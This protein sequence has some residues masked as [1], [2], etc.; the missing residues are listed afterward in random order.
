[1]LAIRI[2]GPVEL[3]A[4]DGMIPLPRRHHRALLAILALDTRRA[5]GVNRLTSL[6]WGDHPP[7]THRANI[8]TRVSELRAILAGIG[9]DIRASGVGYLLDAPPEIIDAHM[10]LRDALAWARVDDVEAARDGL[11]AALALW[12]GP[13]FGDDLVAAPLATELDNARVRAYEDLFDRELRLGR[14]REVIDEIRSAAAANPTHERLLGQLMSALYRT[15]RGSEALTAYD[16]WRQWLRE[17]L[18][19][20][21]GAELRSLHLAILRDDADGIGPAP[22]EPR[23][24]GTFQPAVPRTLPPAIT[25]LTGRDVELRHLADLL[26]PD[27]PVRLITISG[28]PGI[29]KTAVALA[30]AHA[31]REAYPDGQLYASFRDGEAQPFEVLHRFLGALGVTGEAVPPTADERSDLF[32]SLV[33][34]RRVLIVLDNAADDVQLAPLIPAGDSAKVIVTS[35]TDV[36]AAM[37]RAAVR[38]E[39]LDED[40]ARDLLERVVGAERVRADPAA[41]RIVVLRCGRL[42]LALR[43]A[44]AKLAARPH[45]SMSKLAD[46]LDDERGRLDQLRHGQLDLRASLQLSYAGLSPAARRLLAHLGDLDLPEIAVWLCAAVLDTSLATAETTLEELA[47]AHLLDVAGADA[48]GHFRYRMHDLLRLFAAE[49]AHAAEPADLATARDRTFRAALDLALAWRRHMNGGDYYYLPPVIDPWPLEPAFAR[50]MCERPAT[51]FEQERNTFTALVGRAVRDGSVAVAGELSQVVAVMFVFCQ[52]QDQSAELADTVRRA[53]EAAGDRRTQAVAA[54]QLAVA[55]GSAAAYDESLVHLHEVVRLLT[56]LGDARGAMLGRV[57]V[58]LTYNI[59]GRTDD[60]EATFAECQREID[61]D[62]D[63]GVAAFVIRNIG[64]IAM[65]RGDLDEADRLLD[66]SVDAYRRLGGSRSLAQALFWRGLLRVRQ[67]RPD[68][69]IREFDDSMQLCREIEEPLGQVYGLRGIAAAYEAQGFVDLARETLRTALRIAR[70][71]A[72][73]HTETGT[74]RAIEELEARTAGL[75]S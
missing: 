6:L 39:L 23:A 17:E 27:Q 57:Q 11:R 46:M 15:G 3:H 54:F 36:G 55:T 47:D 18:G 50:Q 69:A 29:G 42:P 8:A 61:P 70:Q 2:L 40:H 62:R 72:P 71:P 28:P 74:L 5:V 49:C 35:R 32:R 67:G 63:R 60:A 10:F 75:N 56:E 43:I 21:P 26:R 31:A 22:A 65:V 52:H 51:A 34:D 66:E 24:A 4:P 45:W 59:M 14:H 33:T 19:G 68:D 7:R 13:V 41:A 37:G 16:R 44:A 30:A 20:D 73:T 53:A 48:T 9:I 38:L 12:R 64:Q 1:M 58:G 25:D